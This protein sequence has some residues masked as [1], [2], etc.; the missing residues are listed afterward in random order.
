MIL[1]GF[2]ST[3][4]FT[5]LGSAIIWLILSAGA[6]ANNIDLVTYENNAHDAHQKALSDSKY[7]VILFG[8]E[9]CGFCVNMAAK[10]DDDIFDKYQAK[11]T[12]S[13]TDSDH[14][15]G[16]RQLEEALEVVRYPTLLILETNNQNIHVAGRIEGEVPVKEIDRIFFEAMSVPMEK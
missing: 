9:C 15:P 12:V 2:D 8:S 10:L 14:D 7:T 16:A 4:I 5:V 1:F 3:R 11:M 13:I 6:N